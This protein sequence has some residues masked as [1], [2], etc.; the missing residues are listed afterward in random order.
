[1]HFKTGRSLWGPYFKPEGLYR[2]RTLNCDKT[3][4]VFYSRPMRKLNFLLILGLAAFHCGCS[5]DPKD[6]NEEFLQSSTLRVVTRVGPTTRYQDS[7]TKKWTGPET[8]MVTAFAKY[9][10]KKVQFEEI[11]TFQELID[12]FQQNRWHIAATGL[13]V[14]QKRKQFFTFSPCYQKIRQQLVCNQ[15]IN[16]QKVSDLKNKK[17]LITSKTSYEE[18]LQQM[19]KKSYPWLR[20]TSDAKIKTS[21]IL[22]LVAKGKYDCTVADSHIVGLYQK[23][24]SGT[25]I[26]RPMSSEQELAW[27]LDPRIPSLQ[28]KASE[29]FSLKSTKKLIHKTLS[30][31]Y[32][33]IPKAHP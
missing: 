8:E 1:M 28:Q 18:N 29:W 27:A 24:F 20:W 7:K 11:T 16:V 12:G 21:E 15:N 30:K 23:H 9:L 31:Y 4:T 5:N 2:D 13:T 33:N 3:S 14:T 17:L 22:S 6:P 32:K 26:I 19:K 10:G 25:Q